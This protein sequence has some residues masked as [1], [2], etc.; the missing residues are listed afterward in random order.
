M[1]IEVELIP[2]VSPEELLEFTRIVADAGV[3]RLGISDAA[4]FRYSSRLQV[5]RAAATRNVIKIARSQSVILG[6]V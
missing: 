3:C 4:L 2:V 5:L 1:D 6:S